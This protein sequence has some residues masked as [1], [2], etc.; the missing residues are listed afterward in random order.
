MRCDFCWRVVPV[1]DVQD[2]NLTGIFYICKDCFKLIKTLGCE[3]YS[4]E[5]F[6]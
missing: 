2:Y 1:I 5:D 4:E 6:K 3:Q